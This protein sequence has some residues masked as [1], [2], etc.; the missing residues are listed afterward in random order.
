MR[1][2][3]GAARLPC[4]CY[5]DNKKELCSRYFDS[6]LSRRAYA[7]DILGLLLRLL[8][9]LLPQHMI[10]RSLDGPSTNWKVLTLL[11]KNRNENDYAPLTNIGSCGLHTMHGACDTCA[12][13]TTWV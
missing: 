13:T 1:T 5:N 2:S 4:H 10:Q 7:Q 8:N 12:E 6:H 11:K 9:E 3:V